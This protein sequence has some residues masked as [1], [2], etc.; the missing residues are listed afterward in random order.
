MGKKLY[1][2]NLSFQATAEQVR[3]LF[4]SYGEVSNV[5]LVSDRYTGRSRGFAFVEMASDEAADKA[6][7]ELSGKPFMERNL[8]IDWAR[9]EG[10]SGGG[11][12]GGR[13]RRDSSGPRSG[14]FR[15]H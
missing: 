5:S 2:G 13:E 12:R 14:G 10:S 4:A 15:R 1:V 6:R 9:P 11:S 7:E 8:T 3:E